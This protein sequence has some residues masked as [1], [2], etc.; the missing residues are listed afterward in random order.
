MKNLLFALLAAAV[1]TSCSSSSENKEGTDMAEA[2][3]ATAYN[4][5][6]EKSK[7]TWT[8]FK[9]PEKVGVPGTFDD[10]TLDG[11]S[12]V[13]NTKSVNSGNP[14]RDAKLRTFFFDNLSDSLITGS[15][16]MAS[17]GKIPVTLTMN[18]IQKT[19]DF[20]IAEADSAT[21]VSGTI[22]IVSDFSGNAALEAI[23]EACKELHMGKTWSDVSL[24][25]VEMK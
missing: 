11:S 6:L 22:D 15:Y 18:G 2:D 4:F 16:G 7:L 10:I 5:N 23:H 8:A 20:D 9:T 17:N 3:E 1:F 19:F 12:F 25:V 21:V 13:I 24:Q 14:E